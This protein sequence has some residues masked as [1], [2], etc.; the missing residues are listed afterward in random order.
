MARTY[1][2]TY[3]SYV[4]GLS[5]TSSDV[6]PTGKI[7]VDQ[8]YTESRVEFEVIVLSSSA[9]A[10]ATVEAA[11][12]AAFTKPD[13]S[14][15]VALGGQTRYSLSQSSNTG[16]NARP[17]IEKLGGVEDTDRSGRY[18]IRIVQGLPAS[19]SGKD[20]RQSSSVSVRTDASGIREVTISGVYTALSTNSARAQYAASIATYV[21]AV[22]SA[23]SVTT[24]E[25]VGKPTE[26]D[27]DNGKVLRFARVYRE[28]VHNQGVGTADV[29]GIVAPRLRI[30]R[31]D[32]ATGDTTELG[33][34]EPLRSLQLSYTCS[35]DWSVSTD[36]P[37]FYTSTVRPHLINEAETLAGS[38]V[39]VQNEAPHF[40]LDANRIFV[41][42]DLL[43][44]TGTGLFSASV[45]TEDLISNGE[46]RYV[47]WDGNPYSRDV[48][49]GP[50]TWIRRV[51]KSVLRRK[52]TGGI[53][54][55]LDIPPTGFRENNQVRKASSRELGRT[56]NTTLPI[57]FVVVSQEFER[58]D[59]RSTSQLEADFFAA[60]DEFGIGVGL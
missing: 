5:G 14:L 41:D 12:V 11:L 18:R 2:V 52:G 58:V 43:A 44:D 48:Y 45:E 19:L 37:A 25:L 7:T 49:Q 3:G 51:R 38:S 57:E 4:V 13:Q 30:R 1:A 9:S 47:V 16:F 55:L 10:F 26:E 56:G 36:L 27:D 50:K 24:W 20:G 59:K 22:K 42:M 23:L 33:Q 53:Q 34:T 60:I 17:S 39:I 6:R 21:A 40:D 46:V 29:A 8:D 32:G 54:V 28:I 35:V 31:V 15:T